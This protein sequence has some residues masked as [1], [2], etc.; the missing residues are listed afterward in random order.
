[1]PKSHGLLVVIVTE[2][3]RLLDLFDRDK[4]VVI[5]GCSFQKQICTMTLW[6]PVTKSVKVEIKL[7]ACENA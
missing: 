2:A 4:T 5:D 3:C 7:V 6:Q 1:M